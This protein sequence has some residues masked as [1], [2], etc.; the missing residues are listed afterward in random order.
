ML[1]DADAT[2]RASG[3]HLAAMFTETQLARVAI[4]KGDLS[5]AVETL[6]GLVEEARESGDVGYAFE[7]WIHLANALTRSGE[8]ERALAELEQAAELAGDAASPQRVPLAREVATALMQLGKLPLAE[9]EARD[10]ASHCE[11]A[12]PRLRGGAGATDP[13]SSRRAAGS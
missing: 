1:N 4:E 5:R 6:T 2:L 3:Y 7:A 8:A 11:G 12:G 13:R 9:A 10:G